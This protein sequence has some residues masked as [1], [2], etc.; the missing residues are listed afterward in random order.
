MYSSYSNYSTILVDSGINQL[1]YIAPI[2][3]FQNWGPNQDLHKPLSNIIS[4]V[5]ACNV[6]TITNA[7]IGIGT[8]NPS[9]K[10]HIANINSSNTIIVD[11]NN[12][13]SGINIVAS[14]SLYNNGLYLINDTSCNAFIRNNLGPI[15]L[16]TPIGINI[17]TNLIIDSKNNIGIGGATTSNLLSI[18]GGGVS[19]GYNIPNIAQNNSIIVSG[20]VSIGT[21]AYNNALNVQGIQ[22]ITSN[23]YVF[24]NIGLG[25]SNVSNKINICGNIAIGEYAYSNYIAPYNGAIISGAVGIGTTTNL[26]NA[27]NVSG[28]TYISGNIGVGLFNPVNSIDVYR[29]VAIG[30]TAA[31][32]APVNGLYVAGNVAIGS[33]IVNAN[34][35][36]NALNV[37]GNVSIGYSDASYSPSTF[38]DPAAAV[39]GLIV[40]GSIGIGGSVTPYNTLEVNGGAVIG[41]Y[42]SSAKLS[43][44]TSLIVSGNVGIGIN[45]PTSMLHVVGN[46]NIGAGGITNLNNILITGKST[47]NSNVN[48]SNTD[49]NNTALQIKQFC[50]NISSTY[51][52]TFID[53]TGGNTT[54]ILKIG[55]CNITVGIPSSL[56]PYSLTINGSVSN[57][58]QNTTNTISAGNLSSS[59]I[60]EVSNGIAI[61]STY[62]GYV[63]GCNLIVAGN[64]GIATTNPIYK[65]HVIGNT[66]IGYNGTTL[67][68]NL[69][70]N[71]N[72]T[73]AGTTTIQNTSV[74][75]TQSFSISN[76]T[77]TNNLPALLVR[78]ATGSKNSAFTCTVADFYDSY[79]SNANI[80]ILSIGTGGSVNIGGTKVITNL[81]KNPGYTLNVNGTTNAYNVIANTLNAYLNIGIGNINTPANSLEVS[82]G[83]VVIGSYIGT[84]VSGTN[85]SLIASGNIGIGTQTPSSLLHV[86]GSA[87]I[88]VGNTTTINNLTITGRSLTSNISITNCNVN[89]TGLQVNQYINTIGQ[90]IATFTDITGGNTTPTLQINSSSV[91]IGATG[92]NTSLIVSGAI[93]CGSIS[94]PNGVTLQ[95]LG[96]IAASNVT[97]TLYGP[98]LSSNVFQT[99]LNLTATTAVTANPLTTTSQPA[100]VGSAIIGGIV[101]AAN[102]NYAYPVISVDQYGR[103]TNTS[104]YIITSSQWYGPGSAG[105]AGSGSPGLISF[106]GRVGIGLTQS[107]NTTIPSFYSTQQGTSSIYLNVD[108]DIYASGDIIALS[109]KKYKT[110]L[111]IIDN[112]IEK[113]KQINGYTYKRLDI[114]NG[115]RYTGVIAQEL[116]EVLPEAVQ[117]NKNGDKSVAYGNVIGLL[118]ECIKEQQE[119]INKLETRLNSFI[120]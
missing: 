95:V 44:G 50:S 9:G 5:N 71:S 112:P 53:T 85:T 8:T 65:L 68:D 14:N 91:G 57:L 2:H 83:S 16:Q 47:I 39:S 116:E 93:T 117:T 84:T 21:T 96:T 42:C 104:S 107:T 101:N 97:T 94:A 27:L 63:S 20:S 98:T 31:T 19:I 88:G 4:Q 72:L 76:A 81:G 36:I 13:L 26:N 92:T 45:T 108:G 74:T 32:I 35:A 33:T 118:I 10:L 3:Q 60:L 37:F 7:N 55:S 82:N 1:R 15:L 105:S 90:P 25:T 73:V 34:N 89:I 23:L 64:V 30:N 111:K 41:S 28:N 43:T 62:I 80:P 75:E 17:G 99:L 56:L 113:I 119:H 79:N 24:G 48:I 87:N 49:F 18:L 109:D 115:H 61:G 29:N 22:S 86:V 11:G 46:A 103:I 51:I 12:S 58:S 114:D 54:P 69:T 77:P 110:D 59:G 66:Y 78:Q 120:K 38:K 102:S 106:G 100:Y 40:N 52:A 6:M 67:V 70:V